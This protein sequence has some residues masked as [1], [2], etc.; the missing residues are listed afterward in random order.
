[1]NDPRMTDMMNDFLTRLQAIGVTQYNHFNDLGTY[2]ENGLFGMTP[3][4]D[5]P[6]SPRYQA[7][8]AWASANNH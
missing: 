8:A 5:S 7:L 2:S 6:P 3:T 1:M 4:L